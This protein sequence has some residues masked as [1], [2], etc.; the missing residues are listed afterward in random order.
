MIGESD[1]ESDT[2]QRILL[3]FVTDDTMADL[4]V[5]A[6]PLVGMHFLLNAIGFNIAEQR[7]RIIEAGLADFKDFRY[8]SD[9]DI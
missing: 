2:H 7:E 5:D 1:S 6:V 8:L 4:A 3:L 9:K